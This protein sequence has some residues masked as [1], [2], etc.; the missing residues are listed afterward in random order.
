MTQWGT[1]ESQKIKKANELE[2]KK[3]ENVEHKKVSRNRNK[4]D[5]F[6]DEKG[7]KTSHEVH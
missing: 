7:T 5:I 4:N 6:L 1:N 2:R 3:E